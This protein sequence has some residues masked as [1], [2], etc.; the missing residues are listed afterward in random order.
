ML[1]DCPPPSSTRFHLPKPV[2]ALDSTPM[3]VDKDERAP[4][5]CLSSS[6]A[7]TTSS[8]TRP[9]LEPYLQDRLRELTYEIQA[10]AAT[11]NYPRSA[12][13]NLSQAVRSYCRDVLRIR[14]PPMTDIRDSLREVAR[15]AINAHDYP[16]LLRGFMVERISSRAWNRADCH[17]IR[18]AGLQTRIVDL[19]H[20]VAMLTSTVDSFKN[21]LSGAQSRA[22]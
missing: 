5:P 16:V 2:A 3:R 9:C 19:H 7:S 11:P 22:R 18:L 1:K 14:N 6:H 12:M 8:K 20:Q 17:S 21:A 4:R 10:L 13:N 15:G